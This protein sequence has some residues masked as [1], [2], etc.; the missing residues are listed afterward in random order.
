M[1]EEENQN[2]HD[3]QLNVAELIGALFKNYKSQCG[4]LVQELR[5]KVLPE[6][7][8]AKEQKRM[9]FALFILDD[10][11]EHLGTDYFSQE[12]YSTIVQTICNF[13]SHSSASLRQA[14]AYGIGVIA[15]SCGPSF[16]L[17]SQLCLTSLKGAVEFQMT[18]KVKEKK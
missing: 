16:N 15:K 17:F 18:Q 12:D 9:K 13:T 14:A 2:E 10:M 11:V 6:A 7:F 5:T 3:L 1:I 8:G 4:D